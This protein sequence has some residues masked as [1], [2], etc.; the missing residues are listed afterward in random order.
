M[1][2][3]SITGQGEPA[4]K[5]AREEIQQEIDE[6][7]ADDEEGEGDVPEEFDYRVGCFE[8]DHFLGERLV[9]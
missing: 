7:D 2:D 4:K 3:R 8:E 1:C 6:G 5:E 9:F